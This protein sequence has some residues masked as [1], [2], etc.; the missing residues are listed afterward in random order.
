MTAQTIL[1][2]NSVTGSYEVANSLRFNKAGGS[3]DYLELTY[4]ANGNRQIMTFS[5][6]MK[7]S[8]LATNMYPM[9]I[10]DAS[11]GYQADLRH[12]S[13]N[14]IRFYATDTAGTPRAHLLTNRL[15]RDTSAWYHI[16][17]KV[18]TTQG[19]AANRVKLYINGVQETS[20]ATETY[21]P[22]NT[23]LRW[24]GTNADDQG[25]ITRI[26]AI[27]AD[28]GSYDGYFSE[29]VFIDGTA[30]DADSFGEFDSR[31]NIWKP[32]DVSGLTFGT[33]GFYMDFQGS[34]TGQNVNG[35]GGDKSGSGNHFSSSGLS[36]VD[37]STDTCTNNFATINSLDNFYFGGTLSEGNLKVASDAAVES[38]ITNTIGVSTGKW[39][40]EIKVTASGSGRDQIGIADKVS[41]NTNF[42]PISG[43]PRYEAY[44]GYTGNHYSSD[45]GNNSYGDSF[46]A[47][48]I[49]GVALDLDN[50]KL[51]FSKNGTF[52]A[53][54]DPTSGATGTGAIDVE[55]DPVDGVYYAVFANIHN[56]A[57]TFETN[58]GS[59]A[60]AISSGN[61]DGD[62]H[63]N[64]EFA[65]PSG[66]FALNTK[67]LAEYGG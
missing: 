28:T 20:F 41:D 50:H 60:F 19:T 24:N 36:A 44:Y 42:T 37:T 15:L 35:F 32:I 40:W 52:Q 9:A 16:V 55:T 47:G 61:A 43:N 23:N 39:Y 57:S 5:F 66:Y 18:D 6:W 31:S 45:T 46:G 48:D 38:Y 25:G 29:F 54:G 3:E 59:P 65:V 64:F 63:G 8:K 67:N 2:A 12:S 30:L 17:W 7:I 27:Q 10:Y 62:G 22:Q 49:V 21:P 26:G 51:Y 13:A 34:S 56:T 4:G 14:Q 58:F 1:P 53:S 11:T 33:N